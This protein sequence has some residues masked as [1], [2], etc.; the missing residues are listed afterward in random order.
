MSKKESRSRGISRQSKQAQFLDQNVEKKNVSSGR[1]VV[2]GFVVVLMLVAGAVFFLTRPSNSLVQA[3]PRI[4]SDAAEAPS[5]QE[6]VKT[7]AGAELVRAATF[8]HDPYTLATAQDGVVRIPLSTFVDE[9]AHHYTFMHEGQ[10]IEFFVLESQDGVVRAAFNACDVCYL[11]KKGY[12]R[13][14]NEVI[15]NNCG[16]RFPADQINEVQGGC[17]PA[18]LNRNI[19]NDSLLIQA[20]DI[21]EGLRYFSQG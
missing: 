1:F 21:V 7:E 13:H 19:Q 9:E 17:N 15:C 3:S 18:P 4:I 5:A 2:V 8:G 20:S 11:S 6:T 12:T 14:G 16:R 10:P